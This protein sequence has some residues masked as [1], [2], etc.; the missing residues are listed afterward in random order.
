[1]LKRGQTV[2]IKGIGEMHSGV[3]YVSQVTHLF[4]DKG[5]IQHFKAKRNG[6]LLTGRE[7]FRSNLAQIAGAAAMLT[8]SQVLPGNRGEEE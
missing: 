5:Y 2:T 1:V 8:L 3:Y 4:I 6:L 7:N